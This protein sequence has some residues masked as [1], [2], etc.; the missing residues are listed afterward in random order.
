MPFAASQSQVKLR[1]RR[2]PSPT[3]KHYMQ[4]SASLLACRS[5]TLTGASGSLRPKP[6]QTSG[7]I[8]ATQNSICNDQAPSYDALG[9]SYQSMASE[10]VNDDSLLV[11][12]AL[13]LFSLLCQSLVIYSV[14]T[15]CN[16]GQPYHQLYC[17]YGSAA[18][19][20]LCIMYFTS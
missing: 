19:C 20:L 2:S 3:S 6:C 12:R 8:T 5:A 16:T 1:P 17:C 7:Y 18:L 14:C 11:P 13:K 15:T 4:V 9:R 10:F